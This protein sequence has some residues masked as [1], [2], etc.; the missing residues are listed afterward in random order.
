ML[1]YTQWVSTVFFDG[2]I[3]HAIGDDRQIYD[4]IERKLKYL[5]NKTKNYMNWNKDREITS[6]GKLDLVWG[7]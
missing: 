1:I 4:F 7:K 3:P 2:R 6:T 5:K